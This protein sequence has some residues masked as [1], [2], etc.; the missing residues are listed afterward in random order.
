LRK[1]VFKYD[2]LLKSVWHTIEANQIRNLES[3]KRKEKYIEDETHHTKEKESI[4]E[5]S[6]LETLY[7]SMF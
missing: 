7:P 1:D 6:P 5:V 2:F 3:E 4:I